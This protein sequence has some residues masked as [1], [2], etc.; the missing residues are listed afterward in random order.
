MLLRMHRVVQITGVNVG[1]R[2]L[3]IEQCHVIG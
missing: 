3:E 1:V 2:A